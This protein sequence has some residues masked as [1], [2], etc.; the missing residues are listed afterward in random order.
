MGGAPPPPLGCAPQGLKKG[1]FSSP[2]EALFWPE[3][4]GPRGDGGAQ[5][6][7]PFE[8]RAGGSG[9]QPE[10]PGGPTGGSVEPPEDRAP[11]H[12]RLP[13]LSGSAPGPYSGGRR[14]ASKVEL[15][16][17]SAGA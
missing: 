15:D 9:T 3:D 11:G 8:D 14:A 5:R 4:H 16:P 12:H 1:H 2:S 6:P 10:G 13:G 17:R 7:L